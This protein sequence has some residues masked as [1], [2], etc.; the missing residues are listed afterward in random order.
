MRLEKRSNELL[1]YDEKNLILI[2]M[3]HRKIIDLIDNDDGTATPVFDEK[4]NQI[5]YSYREEDEEGWGAGSDLFASTHDIK[6]MA[7]GIRSVISHQQN[8]VEYSCQNDYFCIAIE[9]NEKSDT[10]SFTA[11]LIE[12]L[13]GKYHITVTK[14]KLS[15]EDLQ[16]YIQ[17]FFIWEKDF[18]IV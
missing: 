6:A 9:Y 1:I 12:T 5:E 18:P 7:D 2:S 17:P 11:S 8:R 15:M 4:S 14:T 16:Q 10:Y 13:M 3:D